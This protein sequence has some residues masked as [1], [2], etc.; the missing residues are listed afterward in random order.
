MPNL[1]RD[2][3]IYGAW[4]LLYTNVY[5]WRYNSTVWLW[6]IGNVI[7]RLFELLKMQFL[8]LEKDPTLVNKQQTLI[9]DCVRVSCTLVRCV[10]AFSSFRGRAYLNVNGDSSVGK[11]N[12]VNGD[13]QRLREEVHPLSGYGYSLAFTPSPT[14]PMRGQKIISFFMF[15]IYCF[16]SY[17]LFFLE[18]YSSSFFFAFF[19][20]IL[21]L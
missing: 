17:V 8:S 5:T 6:W 19:Y 20:H 12:Q 2:W 4:V 14:R 11:W 13:R 9:S 10:Q 21:T 3:L 18:T 15:H 7:M 16:I 1:Q